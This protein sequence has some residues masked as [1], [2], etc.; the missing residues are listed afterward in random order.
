MLSI[1]QTHHIKYTYHV[2]NYLPSIWPSTSYITL[3]YLESHFSV[4]AK[5]KT[6]FTIDIY[7]TNHPPLK[8]KSLSN[9]AWVIFNLQI[10]HIRFRKQFSLLCDRGGNT[11][12]L[13]YYNGA[14]SFTYAGLAWFG[15]K[16]RRPAAAPQLKISL[17]LFL[18]VIFLPA[19]SLRKLLQSSTNCWKQSY[20]FFTI[21]VPS[22]VCCSWQHVTTTA[23]RLARH[24]LVHQG[25]A[26]QNSAPLN[27]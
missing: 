13:L 22:Q 16:V 9:S 20:K 26:W 6:Y 11:T 12:I 5:H 10:Q 7:N 15:L 23:W 24:T 25:A 4:F 3:H 21:K 1:W 18:R 8:F 14:Y 17:W 27:W 2:S 19:V